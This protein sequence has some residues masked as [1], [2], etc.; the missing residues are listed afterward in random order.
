MFEL[1]GFGDQ[2]LLGALMTLQLAAGAVAVGLVLGLLGASAKLSRSRLARAA[3]GLYTTVV[4]GVPELIIVLLIY[5]GTA[6]MLTALA[7]YFG[8]QGYVELSPY[9]AGVTALGITFG[10]YATEVFRGAML[11]IPRGQ[12][13]AAQ[14]F[15][16]GRWLTFHRI[17]LP[18]VWRIALPG[19][20]NLFLVLLKDTALVSLIGLEELMRKSSIAIGFTKEPFTFYLLAAIIYLGMTVVTMVGIH[21]AERWA[22]RGLERSRT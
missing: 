11:A 4:R 9:A 20:G 17:V 18:Q 19:L 13:E 21:F 22:N 6:G 8:H 12:I 14:A 3:A 15:G 5:F 7:G 10:S 16:M 1:Q 2:I